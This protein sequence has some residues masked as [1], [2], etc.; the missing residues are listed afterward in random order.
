MYSFGRLELVRKEFVPRGSYFSFIL[1]LIKF[2]PAHFNF[3]L[4][5]HYLPLGLRG[6]ISPSINTKIVHYNLSTSLGGVE[7]G[8]GDLCMLL[9]HENDSKQLQVDVEQSRTAYITSFYIKIGFNLIFH[10]LFS[11]HI[12][13]SV[14]VPVVIG[15]FRIG[16]LP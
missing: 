14:T 5:P 6:C 12:V 15:R 3:R 13:L 8:G 1:L 2:F 16:L 4:R 11:I 10:L 9:A 7:G